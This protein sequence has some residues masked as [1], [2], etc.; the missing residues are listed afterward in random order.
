M[1]N[2]EQNLKTILEEYPKINYQLDYLGLLDHSDNL[3]Q[4]L[5]TLEKQII[6]TLLKEH[7]FGTAFDV[8]NID[9]NQL[10]YTYIHHWADIFINDYNLNFG[11]SQIL[12]IV[13][14]RFYYISDILENNYIVDKIRIK[15][16]APNHSILTTQLE[17]KGFDV[18][19]PSI[20][21]YLY[22]FIDNLYENIEDTLVQFD[23]DT[24]FENRW[25]KDLGIRPKRFIEMLDEDEEHFIRV[26]NQI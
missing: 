16:E 22:Y 2:F 20:T 10:I 25:T 12:F 26:Y 8:P 11:N 5:T 21:N 24:E 19:K 7:D 13:K 17:L 14:G 23:A 6:N 9:K 4:N 3:R 1:T 18:Y 15:L